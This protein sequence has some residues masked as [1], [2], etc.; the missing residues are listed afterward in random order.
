MFT[1][2]LWRKRS[3]SELPSDDG[4]LDDNDASARAQ[5]KRGFPQKADREFASS[6]TMLPRH[7]S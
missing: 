1:G 6:I 5:Y 4:R 3:K 2:Y 7:A